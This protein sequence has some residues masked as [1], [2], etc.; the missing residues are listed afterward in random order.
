ME[1]Y[2]YLDQFFYSPTWSDIDLKERSSGLGSESGQPNGLFL[3]SVGDVNN[4]SHTSMVNSNGSNES[5]APQDASSVVLGL[6][7]DYGIN[8]G[9]HSEDDQNRFF[10]NPSNGMVNDGA[11]GLTKLADGQYDMA[12]PSNGNISSSSLPFAEVGH[13]Q[14]NALELSDFQSFDADFQTLF[15]I[16]HLSPLPP[17]EGVS[18]LSPG[19]GQHRIGGFGLQGG[20]YVDNDFYA[21]ESRST[22]LSS[23]LS[24]NVILVFVEFLA[25]FIVCVSVYIHDIYNVYV[26]NDITFLFNMKHRVHMTC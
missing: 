1:E 6:E 15:P 3:S 21:M 4:N 26:Y 22:N 25:E 2:E 7:S 19:M 17:F 12:I 23:S 11:S 18:S 8:I 5:L 10:G 24:S 16:P 13:M 14:G 20:E 9:L